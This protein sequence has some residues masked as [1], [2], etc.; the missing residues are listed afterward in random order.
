MGNQLKLFTMKFAIV[1]LIG[2]AAAWQCAPQGECNF[3]YMD[4]TYGDGNWWECGNGCEGG[5]RQWTDGGCNCACQPHNGDCNPDGSCANLHAQGE[6]DAGYMDITDG[7]GNW[8]ECGSGCN[9]GRNMYTDGTC[10][11]ACQP[12]PEG[13]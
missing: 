12:V 4:I 6:C 9:H 2:S 8:W 7:S 10:N 11:C 5:R 3:G 13:C 1:A